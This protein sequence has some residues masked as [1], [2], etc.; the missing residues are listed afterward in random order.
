MAKNFPSIAAIDFGSDRVAVLACEITPSGLEV[1]GFG[2]A[3]SQGIR[4]GVVVNID[5]AAEALSEAFQ[6]ALRLSQSEIDHVVCGVAGSHI[7]SFSSHGMIP[8]RDREIRKIDVE[9]VLEAASAVSMP[10]DREVIQVIPQQFVIDGQDGI[11]QP[12]GMY[13]RRLE[14]HIQLLTGS[15][16]TL[17]NTRRCLA[18]ANLTAEHFLSTSVASARAVVTQE[19]KVSGVCVVDI[20]AAS[21]DIVVFKDGS[22]SSMSSLSIGGL[23]L[24]N[25]LAVGLKTSLAEAEEIKRHYGCPLQTAKSAS[26]EIAGLTDG[27]PRQVHRQHLLTILQPRVEEILGLVRNQLAKLGV[28]ESLPSGIVLT[29]GGSLLKGLLN[30]S[31]RVFRLPVRLGK[32]ERMGG[33]SEMVS[34]PSY[35]A[36]VGML[37]M[38]FEESE[39]LKYFANFYQKR[40]FKKVQ[41]QLGRWVKD[42]F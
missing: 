41:A 20:G 33:L 10:I 16:T 30:I 9:R 18:K 8:I 5:A 36:L 13:G 23:H 38:A 40:G 37:Q 3:P 39:D 31:Q 26:I 2:Q 17:Q 7:E 15:V 29:G 35:S 27:E 19:E 28:D 11:D 42:F 32:P 6:Q 1:A 12:V 25:D 24:T 21:T 34:N 14:A 22:L 4:K